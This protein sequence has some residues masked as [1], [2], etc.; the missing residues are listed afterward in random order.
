MFNFFHPKPVVS[1]LPVAVQTVKQS[2]TPAPL[3]TVLVIADKPP[4]TAP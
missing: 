2:A 4:K 3:P 1:R